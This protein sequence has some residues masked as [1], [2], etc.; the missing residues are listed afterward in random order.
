MCHIEESVPY[1]GRFV[2]SWWICN[3]YFAR[4]VNS[5][6][7]LVSWYLP[8]S[9]QGYAMCA[10]VIYEDFLVFL[11]PFCLSYREGYLATAKRKQKKPNQLTIR[12]LVFS[13]SAELKLGQCSAEFKGTAPSNKD[14]RTIAFDKR[15]YQRRWNWKF[16][17]YSN[18]R[19]IPGWYHGSYRPTVLL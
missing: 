5:A 8:S 6:I 9:I 15:K 14:V 13:P 3:N 10:R 7:C 1:D 19:T 11:T 16:H 4:G 12:R 18:I 17:S 2:K